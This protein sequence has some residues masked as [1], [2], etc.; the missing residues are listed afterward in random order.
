MTSTTAPQ[1]FAQQFK[2][3]LLDVEAESLC[4]DLAQYIDANEVKVRQRWEGVWS[5][6]S[7]ACIRLAEW[8]M[9]SQGGSFDAAFFHEARWLEVVQSL[10]GLAK[11][12]FLDATEAFFAQ[13]LS[14]LTRDGHL[15]S[16]GLPVPFEE[17]L[18]EQQVH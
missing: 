2:L 13:R 1:F 10:E 17:E 12:R 14:V 15:A 9:S 18:G 3:V 5:H 16:G 7:A 8:R 6:F 4:R 11:S